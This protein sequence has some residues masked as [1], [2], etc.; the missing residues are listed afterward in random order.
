MVKTLGPRHLHGLNLI[1]RYSKPYAKKWTLR[2]YA[3]LEMIVFKPHKEVQEILRRMCMLPKN[4]G[5]RNKPQ[6]GCTCLGMS[7]IWNYTK[8]LSLTSLKTYSFS[9]NKAKSLRPNN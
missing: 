1:S 3:S 7:L 2:W 4:D 8:K 9:N 6:D 5:L